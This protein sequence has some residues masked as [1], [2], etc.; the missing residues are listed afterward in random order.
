MKKFA[1]RG[2]L[3]LPGRLVERGL[4]VID[5]ERIG[6]MFEP[7]AEPAPGPERVL[8]YGGDYITPGLIDLHLHGAL[9]K[10]VIDGDVDG[11]RAIAAHQARCGVTGFVPT[12]LSA[13]IPAIERAVRSVKV[14]AGLALPSEIL[15]IYL[16]GPFLNPKKR[17]AHDAEFIKPIA[18]EDLEALLG[19][20]LGLRTIITVAPEVGDNLGWIHEL[21]ER[22]LTVAIGHT[23]ASYEL[24]SRSFELGVT[25]ATHLYNAMS[26]FAPREPGAI[27]AVLDAGGVT[28]EIIADG[29]HVHP[30]SLRIA[31]RQKGVSRTC[32]ITDSMNASGLEDGQYRVGGLDVILRGGE[33]RLKDG[34]ALAGSALTLNLAVANIVRW[35]GVSVSDA[36]NMASLTPAAVLGLD[37]ELGS[38]EAGKIANLAVFDREFRLAGL[39]LRGR[40][41]NLLP[42]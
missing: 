3:V 19:A 42:V 32:L 1:L 7:G 9:G 6:G 12:T 18:V 36:V 8:D 41:A 21:R 25:Q 5:G 38:I 29:I 30:A 2:T 39:V 33:A 15:G 22:G 40:L 11:L 14:A 24:G 26:G 34:G 20:C 17:G 27:G 16:E 10:D 35:T 31:I 23:E 28:A 4:V 13:S 37:R